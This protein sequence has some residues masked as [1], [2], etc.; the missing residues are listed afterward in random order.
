[1]QDE[2]GRIMYA[3]KKGEEKGRLKEAIALI[4]RL[5][6]KRFGEIPATIIN[7]IEDLVL[8]DL[9]SL[10]EDILDFNSLEDLQIWLE[11]RF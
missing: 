8:D 9:E 4:I 5:L 7:Q 1:M 3:E 2:R 6:K 10:R 11:K